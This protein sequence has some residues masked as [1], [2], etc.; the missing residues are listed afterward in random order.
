MGMLQDSN[1]ENMKEVVNL[2][3]SNSTRNIK[4]TSKALVEHLCK[5]LSMRISI[6]LANAPGSPYKS[7]NVKD[8]VVKDLTI[9]IVTIPGQMTPLTTYLSLSQIYEKHWRVN[10]PMELFYSF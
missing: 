6:D 9:Y 10:K 2:M 7:K 5:Y 4:T 8:Q 1:D 3:K